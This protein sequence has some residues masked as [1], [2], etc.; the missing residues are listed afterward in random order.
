[1]K[2][3]GF[4]PSLFLFTDHTMT[5]TNKQAEDGKSETLTC[6]LNDGARFPKCAIIPAL[7]KK[8]NQLYRSISHRSCR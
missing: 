4:I 6:R 2:I 5:C 1:M 7:K 3:D 8:K